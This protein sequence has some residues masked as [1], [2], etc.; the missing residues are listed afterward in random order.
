MTQR[1]VEASPVALQHQVEH[2][3]RGDIKPSVVDCPSCPC[4]NRAAMTGVSVSA[5]NADTAIVIVTVMA[6]SRK[7]RPTM[8]PISSSGMNTA[9]SDKADRQ[10]READLAGALDCGLDRTESVLDVALDVLQHDDG[11][12]DDEAD[13]DAECPSGTDCRC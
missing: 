1:H 5:T 13:R 11:V 6:N 3:L 10:D 8:P 12:V 2:A 4:R 7:M 9:T